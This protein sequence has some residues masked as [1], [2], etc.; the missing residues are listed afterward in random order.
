MS[1]SVKTAQASHA[2]AADGPAPRKRR[3]RAP[4]AGAA[5]DCFTCTSRSVKCDRGR[6]YCSQC[7]NDGKECSGYKTQLTWGMGVASRGKLRGLSLPV[8]GTKKVEGPPSTQKTR[9]RQ[10][11]SISQHPVN[12]KPDTISTTSMGDASSARDGVNP[13][14]DQR[15][16]SPLQPSPYPSLGWDTSA[17]RS[18]DETNCRPGMKV[19]LNGTS[20]HYA[21]PD[22]PTLLLSPQQSRAPSLPNPMHLNNHDRP[23]FAHYQMPFSG[24]EFSVKKLIKRHRIPRALDPIIP[25]TQPS[26]HPLTHHS[27]IPGHCQ[28][29]RSQM[30][31]M[32]DMTRLT[33]LCKATRSQ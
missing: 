28:L 22:V 30:S 6:P 27:L 21:L 7:L 23:S 14:R 20:N 9:K 32:L 3:K 8:A 25:P 15:G 19:E 5:V 13:P 17:H 24:P 31:R 10:S 12:S 4:A 2:N 1:A 16:A 33:R 11:G 18:A 29:I 26:P